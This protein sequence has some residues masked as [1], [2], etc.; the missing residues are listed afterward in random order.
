MYNYQ[1]LKTF[2]FYYSMFDVMHI[3]QNNNHIVLPSGKN[4][5]FKTIYA[6]FRHFTLNV[7][8][9]CNTIDENRCELL[10]KFT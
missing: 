4:S 5:V 6:V 3:L 2:F 8:L 1:F 7:I 9:Y 10:M